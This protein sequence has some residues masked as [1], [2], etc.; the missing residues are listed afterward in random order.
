MIIRSASVVRPRRSIETISSA[1]ASSSPSTM[2]RD[3]GSAASGF[4]EA[5]GLRASGAAAGRGVGVSVA[6]L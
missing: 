1:L 3:R 5:T 4:P 6:F 2:I